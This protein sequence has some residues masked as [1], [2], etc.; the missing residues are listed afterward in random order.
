MVPVEVVELQV[1]VDLY[2]FFGVRV[3]RIQVLVQ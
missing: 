1:L 3:V 2:Q